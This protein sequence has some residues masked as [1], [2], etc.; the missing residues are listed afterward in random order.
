[1]GRPKKTKLD[2]LL[3]TDGMVDLPVKKDKL[4][5][6]DGTR[7]VTLDQIFGDSGEG[8]YQTTKPEEYESWLDEQNLSDLQSHAARLGVNP[9][10][11]RG[12]LKIKLVNEFKR[13][14]SQYNVPSDTGK[15]EKKLPKELADFLAGN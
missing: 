4:T 3:K 9:V 14:Y 1:M 15:R 6:A 13:H 11:H 8:K 10:D 2:S 7:I 12:K 5:R